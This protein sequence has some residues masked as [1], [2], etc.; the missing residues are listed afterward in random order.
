MEGLYGTV[1][2]LF[3]LYPLCSR[4]PGDDD[5]SFEDFWNTMD[6]L[7]RTP[8]IQVGTAVY[9][10]TVF[11]YNL[12]AVLVTFSLSSIWHSILDN[13]RP[14]TVW[15]TDLAI[16]YTISRHFG[17]PWTRYSYVELAGMLVLIYGTAIYNAPDVGSIQLRG[18]WSSL[19]LDFSEEYHD[20]RA[21]R[22]F[23]T[24]SYPSLRRFI[25]SS[26]RL[27]QHERLL[28]LLG[29]GEPTEK[30]QQD[31]PPTYDSIPASQQS[32]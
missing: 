26:F 21:H 1:L 24:R 32:L 22:L 4:I 17:E 10:T 20:I 6:M 8:S 23:S 16:Y 25:S 2:G 9:L 5:G 3:F 14:L 7:R 28:D 19:W 30:E 31:H 27:V 15:I 13:F 29:N 18:N 12:F 11:G